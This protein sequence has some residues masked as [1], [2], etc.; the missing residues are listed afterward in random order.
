M[1]QRKQTLFLALAAL[2]SFSTWL[3]PVSAYQRAG[4]TY[5]FMT[6]GI[7]GPDGNVLEDPVMQLPLHIVLTALGVALA[8]SIFLYG[9]RLR[10]IRLVRGT[11]LI[12]LLVIAF[13]FITDN[14]I[15]SYLSGAGIVE[16]SYGLSYF[17]PLLVLVLAFL[18]QRAIKADEDLVK[19]MDRLR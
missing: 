4:E 16:H 1:I 3:F 14:S 15:R 13:T 2:L 18:A 8:V 11:Y 7:V 12:T 10:Q 19:S 17:I 5:L 6:S 9:N